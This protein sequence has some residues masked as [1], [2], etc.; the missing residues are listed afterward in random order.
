[1]FLLACLTELSL[2][3]LACVPVPCSN[4]G[5]GIAVVGK[6]HVEQAHESIQSGATI[7]DETPGGSDGA[8]RVLGLRRG[9]I[10]QQTETLV[11]NW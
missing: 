11:A 6:S 9:P 2:P 5:K 8:N 3:A 1:M 10:L 4:T 7:V